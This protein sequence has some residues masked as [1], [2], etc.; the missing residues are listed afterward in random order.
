MLSNYVPSF[1]CNSSIFKK[2]YENQQNEIDDINLDIEDLL[3]QC[4]VSTATWGLSIWEEELGIVTNLQRSYTE[5]RNKI[6]GKLRGQGTATKHSIQVIAETYADKADVI[7]SN[8]DYSFLI[9]LISSSGFQYSLEDLYETIED[10]KPAHLEADYKLT[11]TTSD[12]F[13]IR[14]FMLC[15]EEISVYPYQI[16]NISTTGKL[17]IAL[18]QTQ[19]AE[20]IEI[21]PKGEI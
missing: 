6:L 1:L 4:F 12:I 19:S 16:T 10:I 3:N 5:R 20:T 7:L 17:D 15:G 11:S 13:K 14:A 18:G 8:P 21:K 2:L 9:D